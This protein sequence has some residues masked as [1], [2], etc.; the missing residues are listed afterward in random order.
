MVNAQLLDEARALAPED[1]WRLIEELQQSLEADYY[2]P[3]PA[4]ADAM[5]VRLNDWRQGRVQAQPW[6]Q[7][8]A[9]LDREFR[10]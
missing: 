2:E 7:V 8:K 1:R 9:E 10:A 3:R 4:E 6:S 5:A